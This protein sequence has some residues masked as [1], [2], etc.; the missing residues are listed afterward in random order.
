MEQFSKDHTEDEDW[1]GEYVG[2][3]DSVD[4]NTE[5]FEYLPHL[6][7]SDSIKKFEIDDDDHLRSVAGTGSLRT[8]ELMNKR[9]WELERATNAY[10]QSKL[11]G[12]FWLTATATATSQSSSQIQAQGSDGPD[13]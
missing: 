12:W 7:L 5:I 10:G 4:N 1:S 13:L 2:A 11:V 6:Q 8:T 9:K 3:S